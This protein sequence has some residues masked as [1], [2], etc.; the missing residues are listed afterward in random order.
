MDLIKHYAE[1]IENND[2]HRLNS[3]ELKII[4]K[5]F[6][7]KYHSLQLQ[8]TGVSGSTD[9]LDKDLAE[10]LTESILNLVYLRKQLIRLGVLTK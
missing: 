2:I 1:L 7:E 5:D 9:I 6:A 3:E 8:Q 10:R 4:L